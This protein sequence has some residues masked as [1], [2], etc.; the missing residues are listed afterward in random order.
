MGGRGRRREEYKEGRKKGRSGYEK[1]RLAK[2]QMKRWKR[3]GS[4]EVKGGEW[5]GE[6]SGNRNKK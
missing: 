2:Y 5:G 4:G 1:K 3:R 6:G